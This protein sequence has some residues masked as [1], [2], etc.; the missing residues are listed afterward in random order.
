[1]PEE[2]TVTEIA[3]PRGWL[4]PVR[5]LWRD[6]GLISFFVWRD[7]KVR[8]RQTFVGAGWAVLQ[9]LALMT[10]FTLFL[11]GI[12]DPPGGSVSYALFVFMGLVPWTLF[13]QSVSQSANAI[14]NNSDLVRKASF[15]RLVLPVSAVGAYVVDFV[16]ASVVAVVGVVIATGRLSPTVLLVPV[17]AIVTLFISLAVGIGL[18]A[19]NVQFRDVR[20]AT[21]FLIQAWLFATPVVYPAELAPEAVQSLLFINPMTGV[22]VAYRWSMLGGSPP[23]VTS[24]SVS[25]VAGSVLLLLS[26]GYFSHSEAKFADAI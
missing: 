12:I 23:A 25:L 18:S 6:R 15:A 2:V 13:A 19:L 21:P 14:V 16:I 8:Y 9:P 17:V 3:P 1:M 7:L 22:V 20:Y 10:V 11:S 24:L 4:D 26:L 5:G